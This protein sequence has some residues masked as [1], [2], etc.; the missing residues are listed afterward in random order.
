MDEPPVRFIRDYAETIQR[1]MQDTR[2]LD[3][4]SGMTLRLLA[5]RAE[6]YSGAMD[7]S[8]SDLRLEWGGPQLPIGLIDLAIEDNVEPGEE[9]RLVVLSAQRYAEDAAVFDFHDGLHVI[10][11][12]VSQFH[13][14]QS[15]AGELVRLANQRPAGNASSIVVSTTGSFRRIDQ[16]TPEW[17]ATVRWSEEAQAMLIASPQPGHDPPF[18][19]LVYL[20]GTDPAHPRRLGRREAYPKTRR[21]PGALPPPR[22]GTV[23]EGGHR[24]AGWPPR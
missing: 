3:L 21:L 13:P 4:I 22:D 24:A 10:E 20:D 12:G 11:F 23:F 19:Q 15:K 9:S 18:M 14:P 1:W 6:R 2:Q 8:Q 16:A 17:N 5:F 7:L